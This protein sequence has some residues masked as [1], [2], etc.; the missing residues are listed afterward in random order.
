MYKQLLYL[1]LIFNL[2]SCNEQKGSSEIVSD[3]SLSNF[4]ITYQETDDY[5]LPNEAEIKPYL[6]YMMF[7]SYEAF[8]EKYQERTVEFAG[9]F[10]RFFYGCGT[11]CS[12][13]FLI[14]I[15]DGKIYDVPGKSTWT[16]SGNL[17]PICN[18]NSTLYI[19]AQEIYNWDDETFDYDYNVIYWNDK[20]KKFV[21]YSG[22]LP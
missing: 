14:D 13:H 20:Q 2:C 17:D 7:D 21:N 9:Y 19:A 10:V 16:G 11:S 15:R 3:N 8:I 1:S 5:A 12:E 18:V 4:E 6:G 22:D